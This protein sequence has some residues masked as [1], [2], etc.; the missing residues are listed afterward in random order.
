M[1]E[2]S[3][4]F[5]SKD[6]PSSPCLAHSAVLALPDC[7]DPVRRKMLATA[8]LAASG[9][10]SGWSGAV[11]ATNTAATQGSPSNPSSGTTS[12]TTSALSTPFAT[13]QGLAIE[14]IKKALS[15]TATSS[16]SIA[17][18][19]DKGLVWAQAIGTMGDVLKTPVSTD[20]LYCIG[21]CSKL[22]A[23]VAALQ[24]VDRALI[25]LDT[26]VAHYLPLFSM[27]SPQ[28]RL[29]TVRMLLNHQSGFPGSDYSNS[30]T[31]LPFTEYS[32]QVL[33]TLASSRLKH[34]PGEMSV[35]CNDGFTVIEQI[36]KA[37]TG[38]AYSDYVQRNILDPLGMSRS[39]YA[40][41]LFPRGSFA[42]GRS[43]SG[44]LFLECIN[45]YASG[46]LF[47][48][49]TEMARFAQVFLN[50]GTVGG[51]KLLSESAIESMTQ[52]QSATESLRPV[53]VEWGF[54]LGWDNVRE[55][56]FAK[57][58]ISAWR[59]NG[60]TTVY[61]SDFYVLPDHGLALMIT[62][63]S[64]DY[65]PDSIAEQVLFNA[66]L[67]QGSLT[68]PPKKISEVTT[69]SSAM[70]PYAVSAND[71]AG[72]YGNHQSIYRISALPQPDT[73][74]VDKWADG[75][76]SSHALW[77][78]RTDGLFS[79]EDAPLH[80]FGLARAGSQNYL[81][82]HTPSGA[83]YATLD[84]PFGQALAAGSSIAD[85]WNSRLGRTWIV[86]NERYTSLSLSSVGPALNLFSVPE[87]P[88]FI[89]VNAGPAA[90]ENQLL[91]ASE[92]DAARMH[93][94]IPY[95]MGRD[96]NDL[97]VETHD[98]HEHLRFGRMLFRPL[99]SFPILPSESTLE[100]QVSAQGHAL[101]FRA[102]QHLQVQL[103]GV[104][105]AFVYNAKMEPVFP[106]QFRA[107]IDGVLPEG[108][109][110]GTMKNPARLDVPEGGM[111]LV[112]A[113]PGQTVSVRTF[114][115]R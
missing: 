64:T 47:T 55:G 76:W 69:Q 2:R 9:A 19:S 74:Q 22:L 88:G 8:A 30:F 65:R 7:P 38:M 78:R 99:D 20:T 97:L 50:K 60:G 58:G 34:T 68:S 63:T 87:L 86:I 42:L 115:H 92:P 48:T 81:T 54:G 82:L 18:I 3:L 28:Y 80:A 90:T 103:S 45:V 27:R 61:G 67:E 32:E 57:N 106:K 11:L 5:D 35:Y 84:L 46:G 10:L 15:E 94:K 75:Q 105:A 39:R 102:D 85:A 93:Y 43:P 107:S 21:S 96:L 13:S 91:L 71:L 33:Q 51:I 24:L 16:I 31:T 25:E 101:G 40:I 59:K 114:P 29:I 72:V 26:P 17:L 4:N 12:G 52:L 49:P 6:N 53:P 37:V 98:G 1:F 41:G 95:T 112:Y 111:I 56:A 70:S 109:A 108:M 66:L 110:T 73:V 79:G 62:G 23:T 89:G 77:R 14:L 44:E 113:D 83:G 36:V 100:A 104:L